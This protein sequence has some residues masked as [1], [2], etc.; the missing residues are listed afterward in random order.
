MY[1]LTLLSPISMPSLSSSPWMRG[2]PQPGFSPHILR[3]RS[4]ISREMAGRPGWPRRTFQVQ[5][6]RKPARRQATTVS[7]LTMASAE[8]QSRQKRNRQI[9]NRRSPEV[10]FGRFL[11][12]LRSTPIW[13]RRAKLSSWRAAR[14]RKIE[15]RVARSVA[16]NEHQ[17]RI[18]QEGIILIGSDS[19]RFSRGTGERTTRQS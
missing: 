15:D 6:S 13:W 3:I 5:N 19:S 18:M 17:R 2:A 1:L 9:H 8:R 14:E 4:R 10:N 7:G 16:R 12:D 11:V